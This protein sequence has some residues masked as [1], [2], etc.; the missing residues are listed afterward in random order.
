M[1]NLLDFIVPLFVVISVIV[2]MINSVKQALNSPLAQTNGNVI[3][4]DGIPLVASPLKLADS[5][6]NYHQ[7]PPQLGEHSQAIM[8]EVGMDYA[9]Y[10]ALGVVK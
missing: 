9:H 7:A 5:P 1:Q 8:Q 6:V 10:A 3:R 2:G 4:I